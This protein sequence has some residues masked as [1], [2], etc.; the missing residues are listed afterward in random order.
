MHQKD[1]DNFYTM[2]DIAG[3]DPPVPDKDSIL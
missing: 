3:E 2:H 1:F